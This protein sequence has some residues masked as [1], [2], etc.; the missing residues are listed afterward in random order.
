MLMCGRVVPCVR[1][2]AQRS[3]I[4][5][6]RRILATDAA[7]AATSHWGWRW[8]WR[9]HGGNPLPVATTTTS[10]FRSTG[11]AAAAPMVPHSG[12]TASR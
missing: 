6:A 7:N 5:P 3:F 4:P 2:A 1:V 11:T 9:R 8:R 12:P 10:G